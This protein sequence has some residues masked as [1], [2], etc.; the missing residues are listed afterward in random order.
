MQR[1]ASQTS[2]RVAATTA[3][4][5]AVMIMSIITARHTRAQGKQSSP[6]VV[7]VAVFSSDQ[8]GLDD[9][10][11]FIDGHLFPTLRTVPGYVATFIGRDTGG[12]QLISLC[13]WRS[14]SVAAAGE[15]A[16]S[17]AIRALPPGSAPRPSKV[18]KYVVESRD[19]KVPIA[20]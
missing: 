13:F 17:R 12:G 10:Q 16:V 18:E 8:G 2:I 3:A 14:E 1:L 4:L 11:D 7:R 9:Y 20:R 6:L 19:I 15:D 5:T